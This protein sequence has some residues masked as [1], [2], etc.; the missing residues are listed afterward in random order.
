M[1]QQSQRIRF[2]QL[3][4]VHLMPQ[5]AERSWWMTDSPEAQLRRA[6]VALSAMADLDFVVITGDLVDQADPASFQQFQAIL[7]ELPVPY[8]ISVGNHDIDSR[9][10]GG[11]FDRSQ[12][13]DWCGEQFS[14]QPAGTG[15]VDYSLSPMPGVRLIAL[16]ASIGRFP[17]PQGTIRPIQLEW[18]EA[19]LQAHGDQWVILLIHQPPLASVLFRKYRVI[20]EEAAALRKLLHQHPQV[21][22]V[23]SG[24]LHIP[25]LYTHHRLPYLVAPPLVGPV[26]AFRVFELDPPALTCRQSQGN[27][28]YHWHHLPQGTSDPR[29][30]WHGMF[31][32]RPQD[33]HGEL[34]LQIPARWQHSLAVPLGTER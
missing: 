30:L 3:S 34:R 22:V 13:M 8:Y 16:D 6:I 25:I 18:L 17:K 12:F 24:H 29:P 32:G 5:T 7:Q 21:A 23:L 10:R 19:E 1:P 11:R 9:R 33:R 27:L 4:D 2:A 14:F 20:P 15:W 26:S 28:R 31:M